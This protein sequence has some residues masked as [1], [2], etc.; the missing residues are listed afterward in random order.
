M[1]LLFS[2]AKV[3]VSALVEPRRR[4]QRALLRI[5]NSFVLTYIFF[6]RRHVRDGRPLRGWRPLPREILD[7]PLFCITVEMMKRNLMIKPY[8]LVRYNKHT[9]PQAHHTDKVYNFRNLLKVSRLF[10]YC[11]LG[12]T[13]IMT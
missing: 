13:L 3:R 12:Q 2:T 4:R 7:P 6:K 1:L 5:P 9:T 11:H 10:S 8:S